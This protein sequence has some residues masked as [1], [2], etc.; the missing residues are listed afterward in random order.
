MHCV[1]ID[2]LMHFVH[3][4]VSLCSVVTLS[5]DIILFSFAFKF[6]IRNKCNFNLHA[7]HKSYRCPERAECIYCVT[8]Q[9]LQ[10]L[11]NYMK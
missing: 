3:G 7:A 6:R 4:S 10:E 11:G 1:Q 9:E 2:N 8:Y 5:I